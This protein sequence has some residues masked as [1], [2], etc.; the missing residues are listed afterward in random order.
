MMNLIKGAFGLLGRVVNWVVY[1]VGLLVVVVLVGLWA[2]SGKGVK[3]EDVGRLGDGAGGAVVGSAVGAVAGDGAG[4]PA[5]V[6][7]AAAK[8]ERFETAARG[9][10]Q[11]ACLCSAGASCVGP[12]GGVYCVSDAGSRRYLKGQ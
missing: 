7:A 5:E 2:G 11:A 9:D 4:K 8:S 1:A 10:G 6:E 3:G 12:R